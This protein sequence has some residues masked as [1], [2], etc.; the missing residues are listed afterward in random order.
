MT[1]KAKL[2]KRIDELESEVEQLKAR[3]VVLEAG[4]LYPVYPVYPIYVDPSPGWPLKPWCT[5]TWDDG[6]TTGTIQSTT[7]GTCRSTSSG[8]GRIE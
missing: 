6:T 2:E 4:T 3:I 8:R 5:G 7:T 1:S